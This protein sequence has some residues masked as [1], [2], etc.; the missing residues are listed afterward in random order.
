MKKIAAVLSILISTNVF[1]TEEASAVCEL[2]KAKAELSS[3]I[4]SSPFIYGTNNESNTAT[5]AL[6]Y[7][8]SG[9][10]KAQLEKEIALAKCESTANTVELDEYQKWAL[11]SVQKVG[12]KA[13]VV[14][15]LKAR[16]LA[17]EQLGLVEKQILSQAATLNDYNNSR[18]ILLSIENKILALKAVLAEPS[19]PVNPLDVSNLIAKARSSEGQVAELL[20][21]QEANSAWDVT[22]AAGAQKDLV[23]NTSSVEP[24]IGINFK[25]SFG[26]YGAKD[27]IDNIRKRTEAVFSA[28]QSGYEKTANRLLEKID[29]LLLVEQDREQLL[30]TAILDSQRLKDNF[31]GINTAA[32]VVMN[33]TLDVQLAVYTAEL[34]GVT[35]RIARYRGLKN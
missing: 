10:S 6:G 9:R 13:E 16:E 12:A 28:K 21:K 8:L 22:L 2:Y 26:N 30:N 5:L 25:W 33:K 11:V 1:A 23:Q 27:S 19:L 35:A 32:A 3:S 20:A 15:L 17:K 34:S 24:F 18:Q 14:Q 31:N 4:L 7:S 29:Q